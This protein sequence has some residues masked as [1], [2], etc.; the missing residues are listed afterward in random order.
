MCEERLRLFDRYNSLVFE[1]A[2][3][4]SEVDQLAARKDTDDGMRVQ[5]EQRLV[6]VRKC[7]EAVVRARQ[8][9]KVHT[10]EHGCDGAPVPEG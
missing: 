9:L 6:D 5:I 3:Q 4:V 7:R 8:L 10:V 2:V 1:L